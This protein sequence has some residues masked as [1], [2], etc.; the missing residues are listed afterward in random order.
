MGGEFMKAETNQSVSGRD[1]RGKRWGMMAFR[2]VILGGFLLAALAGGME[3]QACSLGFYTGHL[4]GDEVHFNGRTMDSVA[5][6]GIVL[7]IANP[8]TWTSKYGS[9]TID[10]CGAG[11]NE[12]GLSVDML[13]LDGSVYATPDQTTPCVSF[14]KVPMYLLDNAATVSECLDLLSKV[15]V[16]AE[17]YNGFVPGMH[18]AIRD[19]SNDMAII[20]FVNAGPGMTLRSQM[21]VY[22]GKNYDVMTNEPPMPQQLKYYK[23]FSNGKK[24]LPG[25]FDSLDRFVR[26]KM[27]KKTLPDGSTQWEDVCNVFMLMDTAHTLPGSVDYSRKEHGEEWPNVW[28]SVV[29]VDNKTFYLKLAYYPNIIWVDLN[30]INFAT[31]TQTGTLDPKDFGLYGEVSGQFI[32]NQP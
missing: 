24:G 29:D 8:A 30:N 15:L 10:R 4:N 12:T 5:K 16:V 3:A 20:E 27:F 22:H 19:A 14:L 31:L 11:V 2:L 17:A 6:L 23:R 21:I 25:D 9:L 1:E 18:F 32:W 26:I 28:T 7:P 13:Y